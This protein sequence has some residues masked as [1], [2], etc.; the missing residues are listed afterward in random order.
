MTSLQFPGLLKNE[1]L[2]LT[3]GAG[4]LIAAM[5]ALVFAMFRR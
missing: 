2:V 5:V 1:T 3:R 4:F